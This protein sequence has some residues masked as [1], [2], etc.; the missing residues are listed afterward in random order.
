MMRYYLFLICFSIFTI[1]AIADGYTIQIIAAK[2]QKSIDTLIAQCR[3]IGIVPKTQTKDN[4]TILTYGEYVSPK[5]AARDLHKIKTVANDAFLST[6][7]IN[8]LDHQTL[9]VE[10]TTQPRLLNRVHKTTQ[11]ADI[12][13]VFLLTQDDCV[14]QYDC[15]AT[16]EPNEAITPPQIPNCSKVVIQYDCN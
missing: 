10:T 4:L 5:V 8:S 3:A 6:M 2:E 15:S 12:H 1:G 13:R 14:L 7:A 16:I 9:A 11:V